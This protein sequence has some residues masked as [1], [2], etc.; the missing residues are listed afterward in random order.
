[1]NSRQA[2]C[3]IALLLAASCAGGLNQRDYPE[4]TFAV[5]RDTLL[6]R[7][8]NVP[9]AAWLGGRRWG[10]VSQEYD[11]AV[12]ADFGAGALRVPGG[13]GPAELRK[14]F[15][16]FAFAETLFVGDWALRRTVAFDPDLNAARSVPGAAPLRGALPR[17]VDA[18]GRYYYEVSPPPSRD[19]S[20]ARDSGSIVRADPGFARFDTVTRLAPLDVAEVEDQSGRRFERRVFSGADEW[21]VRPDGSV[22]VA[23]VFH[24]RVDLVLAD[25]TRRRGPALPDRI[26]EVTNTDREH[27]LLQFP[28]ELRSTAGRV[29]VS[30]L[31]PPFTEALGTPG[32]E[33]W[34]EKSRHVADS[35]RRYH[36]LAPDGV[37]RYIA[38]LP[39]RQGHVVAVGDS[40]VL[41]AE[42]YAEGVRLMEAAIPRPA[43]PPRR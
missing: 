37:L 4:A 28:E 32:G 23:R 5:P 3:G 29:P 19:F 16:V 25:G 22:W 14:P 35:L 43:P 26:I 13:T 39:M 12:V 7:Y 1:V 27:W 21:G 40:A 30:P 34:L 2:G 18:A 9:Q 42:Q 38:V 10:L 15:D 6:T 33:I 8:V 36:V 31:K 41:I 11:E 24:N 17:A 20:T